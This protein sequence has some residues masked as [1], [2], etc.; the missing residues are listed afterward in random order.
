MKPQIINKRI[1]M[2]LLSI[3]NL[4]SPSLSGNDSRNKD[5]QVLAPIV[6]LPSFVPRCLFCFV[7]VVYTLWGL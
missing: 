6:E 4:N 5:D 2:Q 7:L 1:V 3:L